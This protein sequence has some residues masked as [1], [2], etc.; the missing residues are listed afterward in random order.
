MKITIAKRKKKA[1]S[2]PEPTIEITVPK[3]I[4]LRGGETGKLVSDTDNIVVKFR[5]GGTVGYPR[6]L[7]EVERRPTLKQTEFWI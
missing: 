7:F 6:E 1:K 4:D 5:D 3:S 2:K